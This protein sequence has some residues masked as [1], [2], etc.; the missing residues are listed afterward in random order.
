MYVSLVEMPT[1]IQLHV[2]RDCGLAGELR[3]QAS[4]G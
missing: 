1:D 2:E 4:V 3:H